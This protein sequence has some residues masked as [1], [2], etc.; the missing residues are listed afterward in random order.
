MDEEPRQLVGGRRPPGQERRQRLP[1]DQ[2]HR[3]ER[4]AVEQPAQLIDRHH[5]RVLELAAD[6]GFFHEPLDQVGPAAVPIEEDLDRQV[7][8]EV[9][10]AALEHGPHPAAGDLAEE[11][12]S[13][14]RSI[15]GHFPLRH[16]GCVRAGIS[17]AEVDGG[18]AILSC[19]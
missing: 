6:L 17:L 10:V 5:A 1:L 14:R 8:A 9:G 12:I 4:P 13:P 2:L 18:E 15:D 16:D 3:E 19:R 11:L 7:A